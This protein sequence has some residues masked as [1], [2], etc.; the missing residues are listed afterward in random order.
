LGLEFL[1]RLPPAII[2]EGREQRCGLI[3]L[4]LKMSVKIEGVVS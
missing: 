2:V 4:L 3:D 1:R